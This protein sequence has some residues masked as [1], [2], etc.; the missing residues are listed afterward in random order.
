[1]AKLSIHMGQVCNRKNAT[2]EMITKLN[3]GTQFFDIEKLKIMSQRF[4]KKH[5]PKAEAVTELM[6]ILGHDEK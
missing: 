6:R 5:Q 4:W 1:M 3:F 2:M